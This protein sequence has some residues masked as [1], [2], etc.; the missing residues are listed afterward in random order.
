LGQVSAWQRTVD[1]N[2]KL[3]LEK[4]TH[5][6]KKTATLL[7]LVLVLLLSACR[8]NEQAHTSTPEP[9][10]VETAAVPTTKPTAEPTPEPTS[11]VSEIDTKSEMLDP[12]ALIQHPWQ[13]VSFTSPVEQ[14]Q[15]ETPEN[16]VLTFN[17][18]GTV[19]IK[20]DCNNAS[21][22]YTVDDGSLTIE[23]GPM[24]MAACPP[25][26][27]SDQFAGLLGGAV[28]NGVPA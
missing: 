3:D 10:A 14:F 7:A 18:G 9:V 22:S 27:R 17:D 21:G 28:K 20:A 25:D 19:N 24:T 4:E 16:Y 5:K 11:V 15:V 23:V 12:S 2:S 6:M 8:A 26:S 1:P 13:W